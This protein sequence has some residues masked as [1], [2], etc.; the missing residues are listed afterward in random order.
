MKPITLEDIKAAFAKKAIYSTEVV[1]SG[2][3]CAIQ[4][5]LSGLEIYV[6]QPYESI[7]EAYKQAYEIFIL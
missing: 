5:S 7:L 6:T 1:K 3:T 4:V 2:Q